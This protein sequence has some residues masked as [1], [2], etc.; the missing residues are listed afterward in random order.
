TDAD[1]HLV[2][3][4]GDVES[5]KPISWLLVAPL[6]VGPVVGLELRAQPC[7]DINTASRS[8]LTLIIHIDE[9]RSRQIIVLRERAPF[10]NVEQ[11]T[12]IR[13][14]AAARMRDIQAQGLACVR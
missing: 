3:T 2:G 4:G 8:E 1:C 5:D 7:I 13:G 12:G 14:I 9:E 10:Q 6:V 11:L